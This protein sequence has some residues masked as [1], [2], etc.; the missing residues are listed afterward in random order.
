MAKKKS[1]NTLQYLQMPL[2]SGGKY[3]KMTKVAFGG[4]N[5]RYTIDSGEMSMECN[6]STKEYPYLTPSEK[7]TDYLEGSKYEKPIS[8][9]AFD[10]FLMVVYGEKLGDDDYAIK[11]DYIYNDS[12][13][14]T[15]TGVIKSEG[16]TE[17]ELTPRSIVQ[18]NVYDTPTD[19][20]TGQYVKKLLCFPDKVS[21]YMNI[22]EAKYDYGTLK[23]NATK[24][25][26]TDEA[27][28]AFSDALSDSDLSVMYYHGTSNNK[29][30]YTVA[31]EKMT[32]KD[33]GYDEN[34]TKYKRTLVEKHEMT[35]VNDDGTTTT[36]TLKDEFFCDGMEVVVKEYTNETPEVDA[37][38]AIIYP[39]PDTASHN[40]YYR[41]SADNDIYRWCEYETVKRAEEWG[42]K[43]DKDGKPVT[44][45]NGNYII[46][47]FIKDGDNYIKDGGTEYGWKV[48][49]PPAV[50]NLKHVTVHLSRVFGVDDDRV[51]ASG[52][53]DYANWNL[54]TVGEYNESNSWCS[55]SQ[56]NTKAGGKFT[57]ITTF[58]NHVICFKHDFM[59]EI[60]NTKNP[61]RIQDIYAEGAID[62]R[63]IQDVDGK[64]IFVSE[65]D[66]KVY[67][68]SNP[69]I[70]GYNLN[71]PKYEYAV[72][73]TD[74]RNYYLYCEDDKDR[75]LYV[76]DTL[77]DMW[78]EQDIKQVVIS[79]AHN[80]NGMYMLCEDGHVYRMD[81]NKYDEQIWSFETDLVTNKTVDIKHIK[82]LQMY[83]EHNENA[84][85]QVYILYD[86]EVFDKEHLEEMKKR[87]VYDTQSRG[88]S[89]K[90]PIRVKPRKTANYGFKLHVEGKGYVKLYELE[91]FVEQGGDLYV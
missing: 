81:T 64:L 3:S 86:D 53:N 61:F 77:T 29:K 13:R 46:E 25:N 24:E 76:Y 10:N 20:L 90:Y 51:Y 88:R 1:E 44:D 69:R 14:T 52:Y 65:D 67:T 8:M 15:H 85:M 47:G 83:V 38:G 37:S 39:P 2:P 41:N 71:M 28:K 89:G 36:T 82:K 43:K 42:L 55:P 11:V 31:L 50:P 21:M 59:H 80:K 68:G 60:Y 5:N 12:D 58:Q 54:D 17:D 72:S 16:A 35:K 73:G 23:A 48:S 26:A 74:N 18:F 7:R 63:T 9:F 66:V 70:I 4:L 33:E 57:G 22:V 30:Y 75:H 87:L 32:S 45:D 91:I 40:C 34:K 6:I 49:I 79:F 78:S 62:N 19:P 84:N 56:S 27:K